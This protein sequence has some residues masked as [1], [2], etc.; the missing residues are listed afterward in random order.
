MSL[1]NIYSREESRQSLPTQ[2]AYNFVNTR[3]NLASEA[4]EFWCLTD[5]GFTLS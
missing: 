4:Q 5:L 2:K 1:G 3:D